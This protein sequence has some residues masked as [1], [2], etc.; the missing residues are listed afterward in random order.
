MIVCVCNA[1]SE[2]DIRQKAA[3]GLRSFDALRSETGCSDCC[4]CCEATARRVFADA[5]AAQHVPF[6]LPLGTAV[7]A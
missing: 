2:S 5:Q 6:A 4:G 7:A 3:Q 1:V